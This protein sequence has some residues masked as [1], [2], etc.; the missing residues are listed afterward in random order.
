MDH[1]VKPG[2]D[3]V[4]G[5]GAISGPTI[6]FKSSLPGLTRQSMRPCRTMTGFARTQTLLLRSP[7][8]P[9]LRSRERVEDKSRRYRHAAQWPGSLVAASKAQ[10]RELYFGMSH[11]IEYIRHAERACVGAPFARMKNIARSGHRYRNWHTGSSEV[12]GTFNIIVDFGDQVAF[13]RQLG[14]IEPGTCIPHIE[15]NR[16]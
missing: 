14:E 13:H 6:F 15:R 11:A 8:A 9:L 10:F 7:N 3:D 4:E 5:R 16:E 2:G 1:R 12:L